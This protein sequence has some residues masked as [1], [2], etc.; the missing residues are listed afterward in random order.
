MAR[1]VTK[2]IISEKHK[3]Y[4]DKEKPMYATDEQI[5]VFDLLA[6]STRERYENKFKYFVGFVTI[7]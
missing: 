7:W 5:H 1:Y 6:L 3:I 4:C 2:Y